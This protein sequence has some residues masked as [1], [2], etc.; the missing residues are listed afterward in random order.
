MLI[1]L[2]TG[3]PF[4]LGSSPMAEGTLMEILPSG[5]LLAY[6][7]DKPNNLE[8]DA[9]HKKGLD[10]RFFSTGN[11]L[12]ALSQ[13]GS[14][15][16]ADAPYHW[17]LMNENPL[18]ERPEAGKGYSVV[19]TLVDSLTGIIKGL[20][21]ASLTHIQSNRLYD[22]LAGQRAVLD[23]DREL[24]LIYSRYPLSSDMLQEDTF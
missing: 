3:S 8:L 19:I 6:F 10:I 11:V 21:Y 17:P 15:P 2:K 20:R 14:L 22:A 7:M 18:T 4:P 5:I 12:F 23:Y 9:F 13:V 1:E 16:W 24:D